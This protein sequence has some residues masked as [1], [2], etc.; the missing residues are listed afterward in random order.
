[1][2]CRGLRSSLS[3]VGLQTCYR[4]LLCLPFNFDLFL[5]IR[6]RDI[7]EINNLFTLWWDF[8]REA[9]AMI[10]RGIWSKMFTRERYIFVKC[11]YFIVISLMRKYSV[12][13]WKVSLTY[14]CRD[15]LFSVLIE[16]NIRPRSGSKIMVLSVF[17][18]R[19]LR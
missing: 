8:Y 6:F 16:N 11:N 7:L 17:S 19:N 1:M 12:L 10:I 13:F 5:Y 15:V 4:A 9:S 3:V 14:I 18:I 2:D